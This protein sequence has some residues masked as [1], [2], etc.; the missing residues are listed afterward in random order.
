M[1]V[2]TAPI[3]TT[4]PV[5]ILKKA[6][7]LITSPILSN[8][9]SRLLPTIYRHAQLLLYPSFYEGFGLPVAEA[10]LSSTPVIT[11]N[12]SSL[13]EAG[14]P[15]SIYIDPHSIEEMSHAIRTVLSDSEKAKN[16]A[17]QGKKYALEK[18]DPGRL[19]NELMDL[20]TQVSVGIHSN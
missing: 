6:M 5:S 15:S 8:I 10:L 14:G 9:P 1:L 3:K 18:F 20:Y 7:K 4:M 2:L 16:M 19:S 11:S 13:T 17:V 12:N